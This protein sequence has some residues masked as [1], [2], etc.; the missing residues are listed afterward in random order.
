MENKTITTTSAAESE[1]PLNAFIK[2]GDDGI[3]IS[4]DCKLCKSPN[5]VQIEEMYENKKSITEIRK[6]LTDNGEIISVWQVRA[7]FDQHYKKMAQQAAIIEYRNQL[8]LM[9]KRRKYVVE[10]ILRQIDIA[11]MGLVEALVVDVADDLDKM[12]KKNRII[13]S[14]QKIIKDNYEFLQSMHD[15]EAK[16][17]ALEERYAKV[18]EMKLANAKS[19]EERKMLIAALQDFKEKWQQMEK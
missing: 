2:T 9:M 8:D 13:T 19:D 11:W 18:W 10:D 15:G 3:Y 14:Y 1:N 4:Q 16:A 17:R 7:H 6:A 12:D 5:R